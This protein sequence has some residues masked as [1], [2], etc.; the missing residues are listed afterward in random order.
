MV[1]CCLCKKEIEK[2]GSYDKGNSAE[3]IKKG[4]CCNKCNIKR[5]I[6]ERMK[7]LDENETTN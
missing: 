3:P 7:I 4:R 1:K 5:V 2:V 6:P